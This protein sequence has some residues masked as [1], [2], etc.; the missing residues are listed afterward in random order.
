[1]VSVTFSESGAFEGRPVDVL[2]PLANLFKPES[3]VGGHH[4]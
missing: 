4:M 1:M 3:R 2:L